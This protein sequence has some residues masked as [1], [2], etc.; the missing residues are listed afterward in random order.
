MSKHHP[1][2]DQ[3]L[4]AINTE[5]RLHQRA[6]LRYNR[7]VGIPDHERHTYVCRCG[8]EGLKLG[9]SKAEWLAEHQ[10]DMLAACITAERHAVWLE[11]AEAA[12]YEPGIRGFVDYP[13][14]PYAPA[15]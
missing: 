10:T 15:P 7:E 14:S 5:L 3:Q 12:F 13:D 4:L 9:V 11:G 8:H 6:D 2:T 1:A